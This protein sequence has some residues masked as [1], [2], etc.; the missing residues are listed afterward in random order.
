MD[1]VERVGGRAEVAPR[2]VSHPVIR[3]DEG[4]ALEPRGVLAPPR[5]LER[6]GAE[7]EPSVQI[8]AVDPEPR[9]RV[10]VATDGPLVGDALGQLQAFL[11]R[12]ES[13]LVLPDAGPRDALAPEAS[14]QRN[15]QP[16]LAADLHSLMG[17]GQRVP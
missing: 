13:R 17:H 5:Y 4:H 15:Q 3:L 7:I 10:E 6:P 8:A 14:D 16:V 12:A 11:E 2:E 9:H 1:L